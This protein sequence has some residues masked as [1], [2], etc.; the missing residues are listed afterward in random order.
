MS[1]QGLKPTEI[2]E[3]AD[4]E[5][6]RDTVAH[7]RWSERQQNLREVAKKHLEIARAA[8]ER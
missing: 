5:P 8:L 1:T 3:I 2:T 4:N 6:K 7:E